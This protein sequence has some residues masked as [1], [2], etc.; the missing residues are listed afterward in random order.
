[1]EVHFVNETLLLQSHTYLTQG[2]IQNIESGRLRQVPK[3]WGA[4]ERGMKCEEWVPDPSPVH[5]VQEVE[6]P[7]KFSKF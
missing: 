5:T 6:S 1:M 4:E 2:R 3:N 7:R